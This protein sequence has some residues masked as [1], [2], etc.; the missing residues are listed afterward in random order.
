LGLKILQFGRTGQVGMELLLRAARHGHQVTALGRDSVDLAEPKRV[1][2]AVSAA[3]DI[4]IVINGAAYTAVDKAESEPELA[5]TVNA[6]SVSVLA[7]TCARRGLPL[8]H[9]S[10]D[11]VFDG[12][13]QSPYTEDDP[14]NPVNA[15]GR[16]KLA[17][18]V[19]VRE[20]QPQHVIFRTSWVYSSHG[21]NFVKSML[22]LGR[23]R[24]EL[25]IVDDQWAA[26][27]SAGDIAEACLKIA[28]HVA[29]SGQASPWGTFH[30]AA[31][32]E[33]TWCRFAQA[34]FDE[35]REWAGLRARVTPITT[36]EYPTPAR[37]PANSRLDC[38][39][40]VKAYGVK[41]RP[42]R[43]A[44]GDVLAAL[45]AEKEHTP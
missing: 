18:E 25:R 33:T 38:T 32:G 43:E 26:P 19:A 3:R 30:Y 36:A 7:E 13:K 21:V 37:R 15:Y 9:L 41:R 45:K 44:L 4:D 6:E 10:T 8:I 31:D 28:Q 27:T 40:I 39:K 24:D 22:R 34:I 1:A 14:T 5:M 11:Y 16:S 17:G 12:S 42:W 20:H 2:W 35:A 23:E 29:D